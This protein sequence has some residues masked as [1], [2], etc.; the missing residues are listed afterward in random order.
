ML[1]I[2]RWKDGVPIVEPNQKIIGPTSSEY[3]KDEDTAV[4][5][6]SVSDSVLK[7]KQPLATKDS[8]FS[9]R[10]KY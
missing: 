8:I 9:P 5:A 3:F 6:L 7:R 2:M 4:A 1:T 10:D